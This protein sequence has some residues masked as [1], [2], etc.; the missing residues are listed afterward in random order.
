MIPG[1][2][3]IVQSGLEKLII[4]LQQR[5]FSRQLQKTQKK[6]KKYIF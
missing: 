1:C 5:Q 4:F 3:R 6:R 2:A